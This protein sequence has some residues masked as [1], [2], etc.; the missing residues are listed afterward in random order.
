MANDIAHQENHIRNHK[1][2][3]GF[4]LGPRLSARV[5]YMIFCSRDPVLLRISSMTL[6]G[7][8]HFKLIF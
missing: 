3:R 2:S 5:K 4:D 6:I 1:T 7:Q 8:S